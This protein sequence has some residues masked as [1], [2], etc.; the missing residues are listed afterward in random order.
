[1]EKE[2]NK[3][4]NNLLK[5]VRLLVA[6]KNRLYSSIDITT[7]K[8]V[9]EKKLDNDIANLYS[10]INQLIKKKRNLLTIKKL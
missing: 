1:M 7:R 3:L 4:K 6:E 10:Q 8:S 9:E 5:Q 2:L